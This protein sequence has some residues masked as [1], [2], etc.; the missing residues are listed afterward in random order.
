[1]EHNQ[2]VLRTPPRRRKFKYK[3][4]AGGKLRSHSYSTIVSKRSSARQLCASVLDQVRLRAKGD[5]KARAIMTGAH[6]FYF[7]IL[8][9]CYGRLLLAD[10]VTDL[11]PDLACS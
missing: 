10:A 6:F 4:A 7:A 1:M 5:R 2:R 9:F 11:K 3:M 8:L